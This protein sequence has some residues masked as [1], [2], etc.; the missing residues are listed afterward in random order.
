MKI[1]TKYKE[2]NTATSNIMTRGEGRQFC[3]TNNRQKIQ[4]ISRFVPL[5]K[6]FLSLSVCQ[7]ANTYML[8]LVKNSHSKPV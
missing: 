3:K 6:C 1:N 7:V 5:T 4:K 2:K 8:L